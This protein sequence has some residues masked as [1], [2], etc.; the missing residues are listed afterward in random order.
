MITEAE[1]QALVDSVTGPVTVP[2]DEGYGVDVRAFNLAI[3][4]SPDVVL[5]AADAD[6]VAA[7]VRWVACL[8]L[9]IST[10]RMQDIVVDS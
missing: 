9:L 4:H 5:G 6:D 7:G 8:G 10:R 1:V 3:Q 2:G